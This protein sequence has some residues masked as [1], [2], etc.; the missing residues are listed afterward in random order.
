MPDPLR[1]ARSWLLNAS[2]VGFP[3]EGV[4]PPARLKGGYA[5]LSVCLRRGAVHALGEVPAAGSN[6]G[7]GQQ[8][9]RSSPYENRVV[10]V[11]DEVWD[12]PKPR[13]KTR[14]L[15]VAEVVRAVLVD[16]AGLP[17]RTVSVLGRADR[18]DVDG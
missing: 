7:G 10:R 14:A 11:S 4:I 6:R 17:A 12:A 16:Y 8:D 15:T 1:V 13:R 9:R 18:T 2:G 3:L 5:P